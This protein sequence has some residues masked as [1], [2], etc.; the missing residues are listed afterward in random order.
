ML[1]LDGGR[2]GEISIFRWEVPFII[3]PR[4]AGIG[5]SFGGWGE[6]NYFSDIS[7]VHKIIREGDN[8]QTNL[9]L[10]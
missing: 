10:Q 1:S 5:G 2:V 6:S 7:Y 8:G 4:L 9:W 3:Q